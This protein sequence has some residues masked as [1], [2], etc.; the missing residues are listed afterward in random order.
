MPKKR[1]RLLWREQKALEIIA[2]H[3]F[4]SN[5]RVGVE[6]VKLGYC[7]DSGYVNKLLWKEQYG[8]KRP[9][10]EPWRRMM[11]KE[12]GDNVEVWNR[13]HKESDE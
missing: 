9:I 5:N 2:Q 8:N 7:K 13:Y 3:P 6:M 11:L 10:S 12:Y 4:W 1:K